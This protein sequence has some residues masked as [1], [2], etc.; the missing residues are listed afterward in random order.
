MLHRHLHQQ[1][2]VQM[3]LLTTS[4][5]MTQEKMDLKE[6]ESVTSE[7]AAA[8]DIAQQESE[9][10]LMA[11]EQEEECA[12]ESATRSTTEEELTQSLQPDDSSCTS[13]M[14]LDICDETAGHSESVQVQDLLTTSEVL[15]D[16]ATGEEDLNQGGSPVC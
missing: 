5:A 6:A 13:H 3:S 2:A 14:A 7:S 11:G 4:P 15:S 10:K 1:A 9:P 12:E 8:A 16:R